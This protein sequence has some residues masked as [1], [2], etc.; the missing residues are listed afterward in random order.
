MVWVISN[1]LQASLASVCLCLTDDRGMK[2][3]ATQSEALID[4]IRPAPEP[5]CL[6]TVTVLMMN[7][8]RGFVLRFP[9]LPQPFLGLRLSFNT[10]SV[11][12]TQGQGASYE[13]MASD[14]CGLLRRK[15][16]GHN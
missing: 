11:E 15:P 1:F 9:D 14:V 16:L 8:P 6:F 12:L 2:D 4:Y 7:S 13:P 3:R 10:K 5:P